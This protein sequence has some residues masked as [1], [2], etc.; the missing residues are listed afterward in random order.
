[1]YFI[2]RKL[3]VSI[4]VSCGFFFNITIIMNVKADT[5]NTTALCVNSYE[6]P[7]LIAS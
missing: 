6:E 7:I 2:V 5:F 4:A 1:M 3:K